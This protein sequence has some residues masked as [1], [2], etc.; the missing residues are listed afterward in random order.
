LLLGPQPE[1]TKT[2]AS[3]VSKIAVFF[4]ISPFQEYRSFY[5]IWIYS[6]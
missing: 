2:Q 1:T 5:F 3:K 4:I 6:T